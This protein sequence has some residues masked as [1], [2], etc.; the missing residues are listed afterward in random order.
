MGSS[1]NTQI[2]VIQMYI[3]NLYNAVDLVMYFKKSGVDLTMYFKIHDVREPI[4]NS[5]AKCK[6]FLD[7]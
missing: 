2:Y 7:G 1:L 4:C 5:N 6:C 3:Y